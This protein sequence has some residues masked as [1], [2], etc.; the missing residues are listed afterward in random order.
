MSPKLKRELHIHALFTSTNCISGSWVIG[1]STEQMFQIS[2]IYPILARDLKRSHNKSEKPKLKESH[3][4]FLFTTHFIY[5]FTNMQ[6]QVWGMPSHYTVPSRGAKMTHLS[7]CCG[8]THSPP[9]VFFNLLRDNYIFISRVEKGTL[10]T[11][12]QTGN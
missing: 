9:S 8:A 1:C 6:C 7:A 2:K 11:G 3:M 10:G 4:V 5:S 12:S